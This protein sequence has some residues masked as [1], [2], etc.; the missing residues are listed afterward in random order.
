MEEADKNAEKNQNMLT[1][2]LKQFQC[3]TNYNYGSKYLQ[4]MRENFWLEAT[5]QRV[6]ESVENR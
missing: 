6:V 1:R 5:Q 4:K 2:A 3:S